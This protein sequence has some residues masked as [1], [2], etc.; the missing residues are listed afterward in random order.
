MSSG[1]ETEAFSHD[2]YFHSVLRL[3]F[4]KSTAYDEKPDVFNK[5]TKQGVRRNGG[6]RAKLSGFSR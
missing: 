3:L 4:I 6:R 1:A 5:C 2:N